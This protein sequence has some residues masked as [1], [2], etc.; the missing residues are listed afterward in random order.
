MRLR[1]PANAIRIGTEINPLADLY[2]AMLEASWARLI[3]VLV[4]TSASLLTDAV[5]NGLGEIG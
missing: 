2:F 5:V 4:V 1:D 3:G